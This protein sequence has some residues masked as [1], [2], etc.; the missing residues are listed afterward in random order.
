[1]KKYGRMLL[2]FVS[3]LVTFPMGVILTAVK[4]PKLGLLIIL[5]VMALLPV[6]LYVINLVCGRHY[7]RRL[8]HAKVE[9]MQ[10]YLLSH[11]EKAEQTAKEKG[12][13]LRK[14]R[15]L[16]ALY[17]AFLWLC[18]AS[19]SAMSCYIGAYVSLFVPIGFLYSIFLFYTVFVRIRIEKP[20]AFDEYTLYLSPDAYPTLYA[21]ARRAADAEDCRD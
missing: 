2:A 20:M 21:A 15:A 17:T 16:T 4:T 19:A 7:M 12:R 10:H 13:T 11:R 9:Q 8:R 5:S 14:L 18:A 3:F 1:M 6:L